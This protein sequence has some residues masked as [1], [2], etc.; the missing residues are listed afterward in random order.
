MNTK[1]I[2]QLIFVTL[3]YFY[4]I[5]Y[6]IDDILLFLKN[7]LF[8]Y[9]SLVAAFSGILIIGIQ[10]IFHKQMKKK[11]LDEVEQLK[12]LEQQ[13]K[14]ITSLEIKM[15]RLVANYSHN[16]GNIIFP[17]LILKVAENLKGNANFRSDYKILTKAYHAEVL[18]KHSADMLRV[19]H[20]S[21]DGADFRRFILGDRLEKGSNDDS[22]A[23]I[24]ILCYAAERVA[25][26]LLNQNYSKLRLAQGKLVKKNGMDLD[27]LKNDFED[28]VY[29]EQ[30]QTVLQWINEKLAKTNIEKLSPSWEKVLI[31][32][33][34]YAHA[35]LQGHFGELFFNALK[36]ANHD[37]KDFLSIK[38]SEHNDKNHSWLQVTWVNPCENTEKN[39]DGEGIVGILEE[40]KLLNQNESE[41]FTLN[42]N[43]ANGF[44]Q[45]NLNYRSDMLLIPEEDTELTDNFFSKV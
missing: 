13:N 26:R 41:E 8:V 38:F 40:L 45:L 17:D 3:I 25:D 33:D 44:F 21:V 42:S 4:G 1:F 7:H 24:D 36:Y 10:M 22:A 28:K 32:K 16:L 27:T 20:G 5:Y 6:F 2:I 35:L 29:L 31:K 11:L 12:Y 9:F 18:L 43:I 34:G 39:A 23:V 19:K 15:K 14:I 37:E 30:K